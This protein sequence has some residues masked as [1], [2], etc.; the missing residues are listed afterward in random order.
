[1]IL[2]HSF[3]DFTFSLT[4]SWSK[5]LSGQGSRTSLSGFHKSW[6]VTKL[7][8][9]WPPECCINPY[10]KKILKFCVQTEVLI[11]P[12]S[13][14]DFR[15]CFQSWLWKKCFWTSPKQ[16]VD[17]FY[18]NIELDSHIKTMGKWRREKDPQICRHWV[19]LASG[20]KNIMRLHG[21]ASELIGFKIVSSHI[22]TKQF[23]ALFSFA[24]SQHTEH[25]LGFLKWQNMLN[26][27]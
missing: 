9:P 7:H 26:N 13:Q 15:L 24:I 4:I 12:W 20:G 17:G 16:W 10:E 2:L 25:S 3:P 27:I 18:R 5:D 6:K 21:V 8:L 11:S 22:H 23:T 1:M 14:C 19:I